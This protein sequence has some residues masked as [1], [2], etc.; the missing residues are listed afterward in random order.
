M[1]ITAIASLLTVAAPVERTAFECTP[2]RADDGLHIVVDQHFAHVTLER[3]MDAYFSEAF[4]DAVA[5]RMGVKSRKLVGDETTGDGRR[6]RRVRMMPAATLPGPLQMFASE[7]QLRYDEVSTYDAAA[8]E[9]KFFIGS[10]ACDQLKYVGTIRFQPD[11]DGVRLRI[12]ATLDVDAPLGVGAIVE[13]LVQGGVRDG[14]GKMHDFMQS[15]LD[16][17]RPPVVVAMAP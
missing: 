16:A 2:R 6:H 17:R 8:H 10:A 7:A 9:L 4:N 12:D 13:G 11:G 15:W 3:F 14:Y 1:L 5:P